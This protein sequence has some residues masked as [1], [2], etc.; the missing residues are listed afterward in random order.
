MKFIVVDDEEINLTI[1]QRM[2]KAV[3]KVEDVE[4]FQNAADALRFLKSYDG[5]ETVSVLLDLNMPVVSGWD[6]LYFFNQFDD[7]VKTGIHI[8]VVTSS[9]D[10]V[11]KARALSNPNVVSFLPKPLTAA[12]IKENFAISHT[13]RKTW[14]PK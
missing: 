2:L 10:P 6:F 12:F 13:S 11:D 4:T 1:A 8:Y 14:R 5:D 7:K 9:I 3:L